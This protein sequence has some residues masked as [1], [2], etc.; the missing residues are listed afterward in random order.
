MMSFQLMSLGGFP[1]ICSLFIM[2][3]FPKSKKTSFIIWHNFDP[4]PP[5]TKAISRK[6]TLLWVPTYK[7]LWDLANW[8]QLYTNRMYVLI[9][10]L[11]PLANSQG[12][13]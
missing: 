10:Q 9:I 11:N 7:F 13:F 12:F 4:P 6:F 8:I 1:K 3:M 2:H 5:F